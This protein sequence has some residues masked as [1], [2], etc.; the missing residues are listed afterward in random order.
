MSKR[1]SNRSSPIPYEDAWNI[2]KKEVI[3]SELWRAIYLYI[4]S[5]DFISAHVLAGASTEMIHSGLESLNI[6]TRRRGFRI[7]FGEEK[8]KIMDQSIK[9]AYNYFKHGSNSSDEFTD[10]YSPIQTELFLLESCMGI[11]ELYGEMYIETMA[12]LFWFSSRY[13]KYFLDSPLSISDDHPLFSALKDTKSEDFLVATK[14]LARILVD[15]RLG[16]KHREYL[17]LQ[18]HCLK[19]TPERITFT[20]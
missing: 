1:G 17:L 16:G 10:S 11:H 14:G 9:T 18:D 2:S 6:R 12:Y 13:P 20:P 19:L 8:A 3:C 4:V 7:D 15:P 5:H